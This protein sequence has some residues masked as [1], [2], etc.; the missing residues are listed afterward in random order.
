MQDVLIASLFI[1][2]YKP[3]NYTSASGSGGLCSRLTLQCGWDDLWRQMKEIAEILNALIGK[4]PVIVAPSILLLHISTRHKGLQRSS[5]I[6]DT[7]VH[8]GRDVTRQLTNSRGP[9]D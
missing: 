9:E 7:V 5:Y 1:R 8:R 6:V 4:I 3:V 2:K